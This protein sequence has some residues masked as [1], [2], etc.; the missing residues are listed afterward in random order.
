MGATTK[1]LT[2]KSE[3][4]PGEHLARVTFKDF[5]QM[6]QMTSDDRGGGGRGV[7][8]GRGV[9]IWL[10]CVWWS[11]CWSITCRGIEAGI[12]K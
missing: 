10:V 5:E 1:Y 12:A 11:I 6:S 9:L 7:K 4:P 8:V 3:M 2:K